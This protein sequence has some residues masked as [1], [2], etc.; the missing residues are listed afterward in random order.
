M[1]QSFVQN[2][3][4]DA[5]FE[6][7]RWAL[8]QDGK[9][10]IE[11][12]LEHP[13][14]PEGVGEFLDSW[15]MLL[16]KMVNPKM[17]LE[18]PH[19][20]SSNDTTI[21]STSSSKQQTSTFDPIKYLQQIHKKTFNCIMHLWNRKPLKLY[22]EHISETILVIL[23]HLLRGETIILNKI[24]KDLSESKS[25]DN[26]NLG[27]GNLIGNLSTTDSTVTRNQQFPAARSSSSGGLVR[28]GAIRHHRD[29]ASIEE[30]EYNRT[31]IQQLVDM[32]FN[33]EAAIEAFLHTTTLEQATDYLL[34]N[35]QNTQ[36]WEMSEDDQVLRAIEISLNENRTEE[37][38]G[39][40]QQQQSTSAPG[41]NT[42]T[43]T[44]TDNNPPTTATITSSN[45]THNTS[46]TAAVNQQQLE[47]SGSNLTITSILNTTAES[48]NITETQPST[49]SATATNKEQQNNVPDNY[50]PLSRELMDSLTN[51]LLSGCLKLLDTLPQTVHRV[52]DILLA[53]SQRNGEEWTKKMLHQLIDEIFA[54][55]NKLLE[56]SKPLTTS[57][58]KSLTEWA[59]QMSQIPEASKAASRIHL[60]SLLFEEKKNEC[61]Q[62]VEESNL[63][64]CLITLLDAAQDILLLLKPKY[65]NSTTNKIITPKWLA[66]VILLI[67]LY[68][69]AAISS[70][71]KSPLLAMQKRQWK[72][73]EERNGKWTAYAASNN[74]TIDDAYCN[75]EN[76]VRFYAGRRK[77]CVQFPIML[78]V[79]EDTVSY[80]PIMFVETSDSKSTN[81]EQQ[82][83]Q[84]SNIST[85]PPPLTSA[86]PT[87]A[88]V[89]DRDRDSP[90]DLATDD[91]AN[92]KN[93]V[94]QQ[95]QATNSTSNSAAALAAIS[96]FRVVKELD[97]QQNLS[98][99]RACVSFLSIPVD[100]E[101]LQAVMRLILRITRDYEMAKTFA[102]LG[103]IKSVLKL[104]QQSEFTEFI[105][106]STLII[107]HVFED[108]ITLKQTMEKVLRSL[109]ISSMNN[110]KELHYQL[111]IFGPAACRNSEM[112]N[113]I[114]K[115]I[116][117]IQFHNV[118][119]KKEDED[120]RLLAPNAVQLLR[121][122]PSKNSS[123]ASLTPPTDT[124]KEVI[125]DLLNALTIKSTVNEDDLLHSIYTINQ[126]LKS[127]LESMDTNEPS[128]LQ[129]TTNAATNVEQPGT[130][131]MQT[132]Q[133]EQQQ[134]Q[135]QTTEAAPLLFTASTSNLAGRPLVASSSNL[136]PPVFEDSAATTTANPV[137]RK[138]D[139]LFTQSVIMRILAE[140]VKSYNVVAKL[141]TDHQFTA[142]QS[143][144]VTEECSALAFILDNLLPN[145]QYIG[146]RDSPA[147]ARLLIVALAS[148][149]HC[150]DAQIQLV[151]EVKAALARALNLSE[152]NEKHLRIQA[153]TGIINTMIDSYSSLQNGSTTTNQ[154]LHNLRNLSSGL[155]SIIFRKGLFIDLARV[156]HSLD[157]SSPHMA[158]TINTVLKPLE[159]LSR[160]IHHPSNQM[161]LNQKKG[162]LPTTTAASNLQQS[163]IN[164]NSSQTQSE[165]LAIQNDASSVN[166]NIQNEID[167]QIAEQQQIIN[168]T[169]NQIQQLN[170][171][172]NASNLSVV[173]NQSSGNNRNA[174]QQQQQQDNCSTPINT[175]QM[176][177]GLNL[178][179][180]LLMDVNEAFDT[181]NQTNDERSMLNANNLRSNVLVNDSVETISVAEPMMDE[182]VADEYE[183]SISQQAQDAN[184]EHRVININAIET[185][186]EDSEEID[187]DEDD[188]DDVC[189]LFCFII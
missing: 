119:T 55:V 155:N 82:Q 30:N 71:R 93:I 48:K 50:E 175:G 80:R 45:E 115:N 65:A 84:T 178:L 102:E 40:E 5:F 25:V 127:K 4:Q 57:D 37:T 157:L 153:L 125:S 185:E 121:M 161:I 29:R 53:V 73:F 98:L 148:S 104:T 132:E 61:A 9:V 176:S 180:S 101:A 28:S 75:G 87:T 146:D 56:C 39:N 54:C 174:N 128:P 34:S 22:G 181:H 152:S 170:L 143:E 140:L 130:E 15:L 70:K 156:A 99:I 18:S 158:V 173:A 59:A 145:N 164:A 163:S 122:L 167:Q 179:N 123:T 3:G 172:S 95:Q 27:L 89:Q 17:I 38:S 103:G 46:S 129:T 58:R 60:F 26:R 162:K 187:E 160:A 51:S 21:T 116:F 110:Y 168:E 113:E 126:N 182:I 77:Y 90:M 35:P 91:L 134:Q 47:S 108:L 41:D 44:T 94:D 141:I 133:I 154:N 107:R 165:Q 20:I 16:E 32:G 114:A 68:D 85:P 171:P 96:K 136:K 24:S 124:I 23:C 63:I 106:L 72:Y 88:V 105:S 177:D 169:Q 10:P 184:N 8:T 135:Q 100:I 69:K 189:F 151:S 11:E 117:R 120:L 97:A 78:Q 92:N 137:W 7:F 183:Q 62:Y 76:L 81:A 1:L 166:N 159:T 52:C 79:N 64:S 43:A 6:T 149:A 150:Q 188:E 49:S 144:Y 67:D 109:F 74:K 2:G 147:L 86:I 42:S 83:Q 13:N 111:R 118:V 186:T 31:Q 138:E 36:D 131:Q 139:L 66:P 12:G 19:T 14:L 33:R 112:L 142:G